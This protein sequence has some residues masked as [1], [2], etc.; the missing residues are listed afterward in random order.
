M[1]YLS[2]DARGSEWPELTACHVFS[3]VGITDIG[4]CC[5]KIHE[6]EMT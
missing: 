4:L 3:L 6:K 5:C 2:C 1:L